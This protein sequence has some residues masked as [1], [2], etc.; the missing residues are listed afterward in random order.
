MVI[1]GHNVV[2]YTITL[3]TRLTFL[4]VE[5]SDDL[6]VMLSPLNDLRGCSHSRP[7]WIHMWTGDKRYATMVLEA[8]PSAICC[9]EFDYLEVST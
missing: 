1:Q 8:F 2:H 4:V 5:S 6:T 7:N 9:K 3:G